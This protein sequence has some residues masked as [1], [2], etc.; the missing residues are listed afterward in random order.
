MAMQPAS[1]HKRYH[2]LLLFVTAQLSSVSLL[3]F[4]VSMATHTHTQP[5]KTS[6]C[7]YSPFLFFSP[8]DLIFSSMLQQSRQEYQFVI[9]CC[10]EPV[11]FFCICF[12][13]LNIFRYDVLQQVLDGRQ[14][15]YKEALIFDSFLNQI[16]S[17]S[18]RILPKISF[19]AIVVDSGI[20]PINHHL[21]QAHGQLLRQGPSIV[22]YRLQRGQNLVRKLG[23]VYS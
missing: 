6:L 1:L 13:S 2:I 11:T 8:S 4:T 17:L 18:P 21:R 16:L 19:R 10:S 14:I 7:R 5:Y 20:Q 23:P 3:T 12:V 9:I 15:V 22:Q